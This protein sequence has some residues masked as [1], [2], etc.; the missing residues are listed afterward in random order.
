MKEVSKRII[1]KG[2]VWGL[3]AGLVLSLSACGGGSG[4]DAKTASEE[5]AVK[6]ESGEAAESDLGVLEVMMADDLET[7]EEV[8]TVE[9][10]DIPEEEETFS[11]EGDDVEFSVFSSEKMNFSFLYEPEHS[12]FITDTGA[13]QLVIG[14]DENQAGLFVSVQ[15]AA[16]MPEVSQIIEEE[17]NNLQQKYQNAMTVQPKDEALDMDEHDLAGFAYAYSN[18]EGKTVECTYFIDK[19]E[20]KYIFY[21]TEALEENKAATLDALAIAMESL[22]PEAGYYG[23]S[24][25]LSGSLE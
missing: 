11:G 9:E 14:E 16:G 8:L 6:E 4:K 1:R 3:T 24:D 5:T 7:E 15:D 20:G 22:V 2:I 13:A 23:D 12:A 17:K 19:A 18:E 21:E 25:A 10:G